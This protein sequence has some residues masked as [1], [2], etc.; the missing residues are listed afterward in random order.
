MKT[1]E[2]IR[3]KLQEYPIEVIFPDIAEWQTGNT[4]VDYIHTF[5]SGVAG[6]HAMILALTHGNEVSGAI[7]VD[8][9]LRSGLRPLK[10]R[11]TSACRST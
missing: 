5:D 6:P 4:G 8:R 9:F 1:L 10:G 2:Q 11:L 3:A 7:A